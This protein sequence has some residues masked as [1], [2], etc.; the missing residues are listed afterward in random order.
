MMGEESDSSALRGL[1]KDVLTMIVKLDALRDST[2]ARYDALYKELTES[3]DRLH[4]K[5]LV[6]EKSQDGGCPALK[7]SAQHSKNATAAI[8]TAR[9]DN[10]GKVKELHSV[11]SILPSAVTVRWAVGLMFFSVVSFST[12]LTSVIESNNKA[13]ITR[14][15]E[16]DARMSARVSKLNRSG[17]IEMTRL[18]VL[19]TEKFRTQ[20]DVNKA[21]NESIA[22]MMAAIKREHE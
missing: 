10:E 11:V 2:D 4:M 21:T 8:N 15:T 19:V 6:L 7:L 17:S 3:F 20:A 18:S 13:V 14:L 22:A 16:G 5:I 12:Y 9:V 1:E